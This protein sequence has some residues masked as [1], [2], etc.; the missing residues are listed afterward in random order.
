[1]CY[2]T[3]LLTRTPH[4]AMLSV[5]YGKLGY[6]QAILYM[7][8]YKTL[9]VSLKEYSAMEIKYHILPP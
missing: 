9:T 8:V 1:M 7:D 5:M 3:W 2:I 6:T 4:S